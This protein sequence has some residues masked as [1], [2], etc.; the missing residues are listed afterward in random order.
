MP[1]PGSVHT[2]KVPGGPGVRVDTGVEAGSEISGSFDSMIAKLIVTGATR[3]EALERSRRALAEMHI[4]GMPTVLPFQHSLVL[5]A[6]SAFTPAGLKPNGT[7][8]SSLGQEYPNQDLK[9]QP[10]TA[11]L[12]KLMASV[13]KSVFLSSF[14]CRVA[15]NQQLTPPSAKLTLTFRLTQ[16]ST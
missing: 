5:K 13:L 1:A 14:S 11:L 8:T 10:V 7:T 12:L 6:S 16:V 9:H 15:L 2:F 4:E 3:Q